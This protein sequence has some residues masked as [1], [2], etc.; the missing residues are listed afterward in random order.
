MRKALFF[1]ILVVVI[2]IVFTSVSGIS[3][4]TVIKLQV[5]SNIAHI[6]GLKQI[7]D[8][9]PSIVG[10]RTLVPI[11]FVSEGLGAQVLWEGST[12]T[13]TISIDSIS[14]L[15]NRISSL[16]SEN[17]SLKRNISQLEKDKKTLTDQNLAL[18]K[19]V[20]EL[21][22]E[23]AKLRNSQKEQVVEMHITYEGFKPDVFKIKSGVPVKWIIYGDQVTS[24]TN[25]IIVPS[26][27]I[28]KP[29]VQGENVIYFTPAKAGVI[30]F[31]C[32]MGMVKGKFIVEDE[33]KGSGFFNPPNNI[34]RQKDLAV[35]EYLEE[36]NE[37]TKT[38]KP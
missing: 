19:K 7:L 13:I 29:I 28:S 31:S 10:G 15:K 33:N 22:D 5:G 25:R 32:W 17:S 11:R 12:K 3:E 9:P 26:L 6:D 36:I 38:Y 24:C 27:N 34:I 30:D 18:Q 37:R 21:E 35:L 8:V 1:L 20:K 16:E 2:L 4:K 14:Y 23:L